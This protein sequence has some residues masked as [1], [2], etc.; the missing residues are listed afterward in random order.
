MQDLIRI[1]LV[2]DDEIDRL[3]VTHA[4][5][6][7][8][9]QTEIE[10]ADSLAA[11]R[12]ALGR[13]FYDCLVL[14]YHLGD[15]HV[16]TVLNEHTPKP[17]FDG[18]PARPT[19]P[20]V[21][22]LTGS[23]NETVAVELM[24]AGAT[25]YLPKEELTP[26]RI[27]QSVRNAL[28]V[29]QS[30]AAVRQAQRDLEQRVIERTAELAAANRELELEMVNRHKAE[31]RAREHL[32]QLAH[33]ARLS[34][35]G[36]MA[37][38]LAHELNQPLGAIAN[39]AHGCS[40]R[41]QNETA[42]LDMVREVFDKIALQ[43]ERA[44]QIIHRLRRL[45]SR[46][47]PDLAP[48]DLNR[49]IEEVVGLQAGEAAQRQIALT[50]QLSP[51]LRP[52]RVDGILVQQVVLNLIRNSIDAVSTLEPQ[53]RHVTLRTETAG[54]DHLRVS[55]I[56]DGP[57]CAPDV[58]DRLFDPFFTTKNRG[59][60]MGLAI[61]RSIIESHNGELWVR[62]NPEHGLTFFF[63]LPTETTAPTGTEATEGET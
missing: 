16:T 42:D 58:L 13:S 47:Q 41:I 8:G 20:P 23:G 2:D 54:S 19:L 15:G 46:R 52:V 35:L 6:Q 38:E 25:D 3:A 24:R 39:Y 36:E 50:L 61:C 57:G 30:E 49:L 22:I 32:E 43:A 27:A 31:G 29:H 28:R 40:K 11:L 48:A 26:S 34:T 14:D 51:S 63:T 56:D 21:I 7:S 12:L 5:R 33:V 37:A 59:M 53:R 60:G 18:E 1:L 17:S 4:L 45:V 9:L 10:E 62:P 44:G 55:V